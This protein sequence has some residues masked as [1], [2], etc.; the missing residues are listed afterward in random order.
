MLLF[1]VLVLLALAPGAVLAQDEGLAEARRLAAAGQRTEALALIET[2]LAERPE[3]VDA[4]LLYGLVLSWEERFDEARV[5]LERVL[6]S[7][8]DYLDA[9]VAL[10]NVAW[11][12]GQ[13]PEARRLA[14]EVLERQPGHPQ[15][16]LVRQRADGRARPWQAGIL[17]S[18]DDF[19]DARDDWHETALFAGYETAAGPII[20]RGSRASRFATTDD[21]FEAE[22]Y[23]RIRAGTYAMVTAG[24][25][26]DATLFPEWRVGL[27]LNQ[28]LGRGFEASAGIRRLAFDDPVTIYVGAL[29]KYAG[30]WLLSGRVFH[31]PDD[32]T[33]RTTSYSA[34]A[35]WYGGPT[36]ASVAGVT[37]TRGF[38]RDEV[39]NVADLATRDSDT[40]RVQLDLELRHGLIVVIGGALARQE[41]VPGRRRLQATLTTGLTARF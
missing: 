2:R 36:G 41:P 7:A 35:R 24:F 13:A 34:S 15:A 14:A 1:R 23:P 12:S 17:Y 18:Y 10:M 4:R 39:R 29:S 30:P 28:A 40:V 5:E 9:R 25:S 32:G 26:P 20:A 19:S 3:D 21:Q 38:S 27:D 37:Y 16:L 11:W 6:A 22:F 31:V 33:G 8:P